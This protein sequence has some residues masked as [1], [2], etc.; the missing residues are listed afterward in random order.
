MPK[1]PKTEPAPETAAA[2]A[3]AEVKTEEQPAAAKS[4]LERNAE[5]QAQPKKP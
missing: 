1:P 5:R 3:V 2:P 4:L